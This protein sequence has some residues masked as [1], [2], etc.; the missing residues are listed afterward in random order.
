[1][2]ILEG[3]KSEAMARDYLLRQGLQWRESNY[4]SRMGE[5]DLIMQDATHVIFV[6]VRARRSAVFGGALA[7]IT[8]AKRQKLL[9]TAMCYLQQHRLYDSHASRFDVLTLQGQPPVID[10]LQNAFGT[11]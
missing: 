10:W 6:E 7:S 3:A 1:M 9:K 5:I 4:R 2:S 11:D 8:H